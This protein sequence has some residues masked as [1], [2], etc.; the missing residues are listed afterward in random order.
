MFRLPFR[1]ATPFLKCGL[2][3]VDQPHGFQSPCD[4]SKPRCCEHEYAFGSCNALGGDWSQGMKLIF[5]EMIQGEK[6]RGEE[7]MPRRAARRTRRALEVTVAM[8]VWKL[9]EAERGG[10]RGARPGTESWR[11]VP[12]CAL[13]HKPCSL[14]LSPTS[15]NKN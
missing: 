7:A 5:W 9:E 13:G 14:G 6:Q 2:A 1:P 4:T 8:S 10:P 15:A 11:L 3:L 12:R